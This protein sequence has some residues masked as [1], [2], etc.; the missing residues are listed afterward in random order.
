M[1]NT[2][3]FAVL[4]LLA[5][6]G[7]CSKD[8]G[9]LG[10]GDYLTSTGESGSSVNNQQGQ[11]GQVTAGEWNDLSNWEFW[12]NL[13]NNQEFSGM[14]A[15]WNFYTNNR[16]SVVVNNQGNPFVNAKV[17]LLRNET[18][19]W[20]ARTDNSGKA[21]LWTGMFQQENSI[22]LNSLK[23]KI[24]N[25]LQNQ[26]LVLFEN[27]T[28]EFNINTVINNLKRV[29]IAF[30]VDATG[31]MGDELEFLKE[32]LKSVIDS[33]KLEDSNLEIYTGT[34]FYRDEGD[35][36]VVRKS[37]FTNNLN[38]TINF[39]ND[40]SA[41][42]GGDFPEAVHTALNEGINNLQWSE[43][44]KTRIAF[45][46]LD[47]PPHYKTAI[48]NSIHSSIQLA[49]QKGI[50]II[51]ITASGIDK[52]TEFLMRFM[53]IMTNGTYIF[54]TNDSGIGNDHLEASVGE[55]QVEKLNSLMIRLI[56]KYSY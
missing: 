47:A 18:V 6:F 55:Y 8:E 34:V 38:S 48:V 56:K 2:L 33:V 35:E 10:S 22:D 40:Q 19:I 42:G 31:S 24:N 17:E 36:Y 1:K 23:L 11:A 44:A 29:E 53:S 27:G 13:F 30:I 9:D 20:S 45:L 52:Q 32:D 39:I 7:S 43:T 25:V 37:A 14:S 3:I 21:E 28:N 54:I 5:C 50:K 51:P 26:E 46:L 16:I 4:I 41:S 49:A 12:N 15:Y